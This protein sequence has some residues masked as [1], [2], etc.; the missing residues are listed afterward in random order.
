MTTNQHIKPATVER[1][2][3]LFIGGCDTVELAKKYGTP[4]YVVDETTLRNICHDYK[5]AFKSYPHTRMMYASKALCTSTIVK[6]L[7]EEGFG[8]DTVSIGE[9]HTVLNSG[10][11]LSHV[12]FNGNNKTERELDYAIK[13][14]ISRI[15][16]DN[17]Y[18]IDLVSKVA[19][20][21]N[22]IV[23]VLLRISPGIECHTH[24]YIKTGQLDSK[25]GFDLS[26]LDEAVTSILTRHQNI[27]IRGLHAHIGSQIFEP[28]CFHDE[29]DVLT[30]TLGEISTKY[31]IVLDE[32]NIGGGIGVKYV[33]SD[34]PPSINEI[35]DVII[36]SLDK[37]IAKYNIEPPTL[38]IEPGRSIISTSGVT[39][40]TIGSMKQVPNMTKYV[41]VDGGMADNPRPSMYQAEY[42][43]EVAN[44]VDETQTEKVTI[45][46]RYCES[47]DILIKDIMLPKLSTGDI[48]CVYNTGS[49][50]Y[51]MASNYNR[52]EKPAMVLVNNSQSDIIVKR[53]TLDDLVSHDV[54]PD[55]LK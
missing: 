10:V 14:G 15:S 4:L 51:S 2:E 20:R 9:I 24:E 16:V 31:N 28:S 47:G 36:E 21:Y 40:Y 41:T 44:K 17:F 45:A 50:N 1:K 42:L 35:A 5:N 3:N 27:K 46:G 43:A 32:I 13:N 54:V 12:L 26:Q 30:Q 25:F 7:D 33:D 23:D 8:F 34:L 49:Y 18:E 38:Y 39:L 48:L 19:G 37:H 11:E 53:E 29:I 22:K 55:R 52:V 6:I